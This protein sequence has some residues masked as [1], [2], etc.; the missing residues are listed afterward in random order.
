MS[1]YPKFNCPK[2]QG[3]SRTKDGHQRCHDNN[4]YEETKKYQ[5]YFPPYLQA[6]DSQA[7]RVFK[8]TEQIRPETWAEIRASLIKHASL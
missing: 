2:C 1:A 7:G 5:R 6:P 8:T 3:L 4:S